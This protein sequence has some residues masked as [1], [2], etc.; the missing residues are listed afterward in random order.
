M[1]NLK[2]T[3]KLTWYVVLLL[4]EE[5][6]FVGHVCGRPLLVGTRQVEAEPEPDAPTTLSFDRRHFINEGQDTRSFRKVK[7]QISHNEHE[8]NCVFTINATKL[9]IFK[10]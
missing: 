6:Y 8:R 10:T 1:D 2:K 4:Q 7:V 9:L 3:L 5:S